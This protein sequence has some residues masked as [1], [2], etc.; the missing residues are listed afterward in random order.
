MDPR[1]VLLGLSAVLLVAC[2]N[3]GTVSQVPAPATTAPTTTASPAPTVTP[4]T[5][6]NAP[7]VSPT[8]SGAADVLVGGDR[9][10]TVHVPAAYDPG[11]PAPLL[12]VLHG[13]GGSGKDI[14]DELRLGAAAAQ[15]GY[16]SV[17]PD[18]TLDSTVSRFWNATDACCDFEGAGVD[19]ATY[20]EGVIK[21]IQAK[22]TVDPRRIDVV[23][24]SNGAFMSYAM[25]CAHADTIA[26]IVS[27]AGA[28]FKDPKA[29]APKDP[30]AV[31]EIHGTADDTIYFDGGTI[32]LSGG[33]AMGAY[34]GA[35]ASVATW[36]KYDG[37]ATS[38]VVDEHV[39]VDATLGTAAAPAEATV[40]RWAGCKP[41]G[42]VE[43]WTV[44]GGGHTPTVSD[45]FPRAVLDFLES[46]PK[47]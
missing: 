8:S 38:S 46:H 25:A 19:D 44:P 29:C 21:D 43:L 40:T 30:V 17:A 41:G 37:C 22:F 32:T 36:A 31:L 14:E 4:S 15:R 47:P 39:D 35:R 13:Y 9:P 6:P 33:H 42:A 1:R 28:T 18:G 16:L 2:S 34:P 12:V 24:H 45:S 3:A 23:G 27:L 11:K 7:A 26:A 5:T 10:A 20:L